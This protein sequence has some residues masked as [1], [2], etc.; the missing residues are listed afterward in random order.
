M[1][2]VT[3]INKAAVKE[4]MGRKADL[5]AFVNVCSFHSHLAMKERPPDCVS[6]T[7]DLMNTLNHH[8]KFIRYLADWQRDARVIFDSMLK[9][10]SNENVE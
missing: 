5:G 2:K 7:H 1:T 9:E 3:K 4:L 10:D 6:C 8:G